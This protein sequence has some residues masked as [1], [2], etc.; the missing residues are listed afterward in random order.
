MASG[1]GIAIIARTFSAVVMLVT[2]LCM[3]GCDED[4]G[5]DADP[6]PWSAPV[7]AAALRPAQ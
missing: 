3:S 4:A 5:P 6:S 1:K 7:D 2:A